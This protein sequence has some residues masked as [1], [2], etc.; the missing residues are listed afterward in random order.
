MIKYLENINFLKDL[1][2]I[3]NVLDELSLL[4]L[5]LQERNMTVVKADRLIR[6]TIRVFDSMKLNK[7]VYEK[8]ADDIIN[9]NKYVK[10][11]FKEI[12]NKKAIPMDKL[13]D[14]LIKFMK[15]RLLFND[16]VANYNELISFLNILNPETFLINI[17]ENP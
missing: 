4:S 9:K 11:D 13:L 7:G 6:R 10:I 17:I 5:S 3:A 12:K 15:M 2:L 8:E 16:K 14:S 1:A